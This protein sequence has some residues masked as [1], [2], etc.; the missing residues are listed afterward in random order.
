MSHRVL[1]ASPDVERLEALVDEYSLADVLEAL[2]YICHEQ[3]E[4]VRAARQD[5]PLAQ[6]LEQDKRTID[7]TVDQLV[8]VRCRVCGERPNPPICWRCSVALER[9]RLGRT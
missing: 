6:S 1:F 9:T 4:H 3:A 8:S 2:A 7:Q 5:E